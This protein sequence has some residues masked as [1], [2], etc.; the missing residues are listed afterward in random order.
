MIDRR[1]VHS[2]AQGPLGIG[3]VDLDAHGSRRRVFGFADPRRLVPGTIAPQRVDLD[4]GRVA[5]ISENH[6]AIRHA[7]DHAHQVIPLDRQQRRLPPSVA[8]RMNA[9]G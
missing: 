4:H 9:P 7:N 2:L 5:D 6:V 8:E 1:A 3:Q